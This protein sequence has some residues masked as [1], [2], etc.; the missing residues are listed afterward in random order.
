[1]ADEALRDLPPWEAQEP[2]GSNDTGDDAGDRWADIPPGVLPDPVGEFVA[3]AATAIGCTRA[4]VATPLLAAL[5]AAIGTK[6]A[7]EI[8]P[9][10]LEFPLVW[11]AVVADS[12]GFK[13]PAMRVA[14]QFVKAR[15]YAAGEDAAAIIAEHELELDAYDAARE[16]WR[17]EA[18]KGRAGDPPRKPKRPPMQR[19][20]IDDITIEALAPILADNPAG[21]L[22]GKDELGGWLSS[23]DRYSGKGGGDA[24]RWLS[25]FTAEP[26]SV[27]RKGGGR[28][29]VPAAAVGICGC[30]PPRTFAKA[31]GSDHVDNGLLPRFLVAM[32]PR[33]RK[34]WTERAVGFATRDAMASVF[35]RLYSLQPLDTGPRAVEFDAA[36]RETWVNF[37]DEHA[38]EQA[39]ATGVVASMLSKIE[40]YAARLALIVHACR[41]SAE[42][43]GRISASSV[44]AGVTLAR[45]YTAEARRVYRAVVGTSGDDGSA[46]VAWIRNQGGRASPREV[47]RGAPGYAGDTAR[48]EAA[49]VRLVRAGAARWEAT[50]TGGRP[51]DTVVLV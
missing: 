20:L 18:A 3:E 49:L 13:S 31:L 26:L 1:M 37:Y 44:G 10:W 4:H 23:F 2:H 42:A 22:V 21:V 6:L 7:V 30:I 8:K 34:E 47:A 17:R 40:A 41:P 15:E 50:A 45:W 27:D 29:Y 38:G 46:L 9:G 51:R 39:A 28:I 43:E 12:G 35:G 32:P 24:A 11:S 36:G 33:R 19:Y 5:G 16:L 14:L 48:A 25:T